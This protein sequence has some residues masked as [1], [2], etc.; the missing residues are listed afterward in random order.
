MHPFP[1]QPKQI[2][3]SPLNSPPQKCKQSAPTGAEITKIVDLEKFSEECKNRL[4][5][6][7]NTRDQVNYF[8]KTLILKA[9]ECIPKVSTKK[10]HSKPCCKK[11]IQLRRPTL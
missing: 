9:T 5:Q 8:T 1:T 6:N 7:Y 11:A 10:I 3:K 2:S 4:P